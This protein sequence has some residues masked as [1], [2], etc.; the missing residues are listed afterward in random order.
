MSPTRYQTA[1]SRGAHYID[2]QQVVKRYLLKKAISWKN[3]EKTAQSGDCST[4]YASH[5]TVWLRPFCYH[6]RPYHYFCFG[7]HVENHPYHLYPANSRAGRLPPP[8]PQRLHTHY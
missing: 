8:D 2:P 1:P 6:A 3:R 4:G 7:H 5:F